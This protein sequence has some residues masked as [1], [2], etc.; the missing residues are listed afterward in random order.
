MDPV[1][2][3]ASVL[4]QLRQRERERSAVSHW[5]VL[6]T[7]MFINTSNSR[8]RTVDREFVYIIW[9]SVFCWALKAPRSRMNKLPECQM[10]AT[11]HTDGWPRQLECSRC[12]TVQRFSP[13]CSNR[14]LYND[15]LSMFT[16]NTTVRQFSSML[17]EKAQKYNMCQR[18]LMTIHDGTTIKI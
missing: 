6:R 13:I 2:V 8:P 12:Y 3:S 1:L 17:N 11:G 4:Y 15:F 5:L 18:C 7:C 10:A 9:R 14:R 16:E